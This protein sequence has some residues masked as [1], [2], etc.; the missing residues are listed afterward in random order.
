GHSRSVPGAAI[1]WGRF[2]LPCVPPWSI[3]RAYDTPGCRQLA[4][5]RLRISPLASLEGSQ[6]LRLHRFHPPAEI[7]Q[8]FPGEDFALYLGKELLLLFA[9][10]VL[11]VLHQHFQP[12]QPGVGA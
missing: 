12:G 6:A 1:R 4:E 9:N 2:W 7:I 8:L 3:S 11:H 5:P 10:M